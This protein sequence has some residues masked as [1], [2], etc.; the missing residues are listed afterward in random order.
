M[1]LLHRLR[2]APTTR[3]L[4]TIASHIA[5]RCRWN[6]MIAMAVVLVSIVT[7][8]V[9]TLASTADHITVD[10]TAL[11]VSG[12]QETRPVHI[13]APTPRA[14]WSAGTTATWLTVS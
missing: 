10:T 11:S 6:G 4:R 5:R 13:T 14:G 2:M 1:N 9:P 8:G 7:L 3:A 12:H